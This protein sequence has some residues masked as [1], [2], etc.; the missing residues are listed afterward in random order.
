[1]EEPDENDEAF[2]KF[3][4]VMV[5]LEWYLIRSCYDLQREKERWMPGLKRL[6]RPESERG[7]ERRMM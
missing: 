2:G 3:V 4:G 5:Y 7:L 1:L 6:A